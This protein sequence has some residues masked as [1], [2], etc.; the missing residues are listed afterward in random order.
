MLEETS[1]KGLSQDRPGGLGGQRGPGGIYLLSALGL[2]PTACSLCL[3][4]AV[5]ARDV[6]SRVEA[7]R[8]VVLVCDDP[9][10]SAGSRRGSK[11]HRT[12]VVGTSYV[13][14]LL[15]AGSRGE[16]KEVSTLY[17]YH[18][19]VQA[20]GQG[21]LAAKL[22]QLWFTSNFSSGWRRRGSDKRNET[23]SDDLKGSTDAHC[24]SHTR[25]VSP[26]SSSS[27]AQ[28]IMP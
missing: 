19:R 18:V 25:S 16:I 12:S 5:E 26:I 3:H 2:L 9:G 6:L 27:Q 17:P 13:Q 15:K 1:G 24:T 7:S 23:V 11:W 4:S 22:Q 21:E 10:G 14:D 20:K 28:Q 8:V